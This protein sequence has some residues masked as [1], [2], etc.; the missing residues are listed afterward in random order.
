V[1][2]I[3]ARLKGK[4]G[5][6]RGNLMEKHIDPPACTVITGDPNLEL[7]EVGVPRSIAMNLMYPE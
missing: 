6:L 7:D 4:E 3:C 2:A 1:K 5:C